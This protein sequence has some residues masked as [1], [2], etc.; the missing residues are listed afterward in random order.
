MCAE[1][2][3][4]WTIYAQSVDKFSSVFKIILQITCRNLRLSVSLF[5]Q[6]QIIKYRIVS[7]TAAFRGA[8]KHADYV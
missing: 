8:E 1:H 7:T 6:K 5:L 3:A 4:S 2:A